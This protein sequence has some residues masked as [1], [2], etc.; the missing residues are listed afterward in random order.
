MAQG[1]PAPTSPQPDAVPPPPA[2]TEPALVPPPPAL[3][4]EP[5]TVAPAT[6]SPSTESP[7]QPM[8]PE[9]APALPLR[10]NVNPEAP[11]ES[12]PVPVKGKWNP[13]LYGFVEFD[14][15]HD[16]TQSFNDLAGNAPI[17]TGFQGSHPRTM[18]SVRNSRLGFK[19]SAPETSGIRATGVLEMDFLGNQPTDASENALFTNPTFR[20]RHFALKLENRYVDVLLGQYWQ[21]FGWQSFFHPNTVEI[22]GVP[23]QVYTR[24]PQARLSHKFDTD[25]VTVELAA[26]ASRPVERDSGVPDLTAGLRLSING[27]KGLHTSGAGATATAQDAM[28]IGVSAIGRHLSVPEFSASPSDTVSKNAGGISIDAM[29]PVIPRSLEHRGNA[30]TLTG[31]FVTG[32]GISDLYTGLTGG[33][34]YPS[35]P[36]PTNAAPAPTYTADL[37]K[38]IATFDSNGN[39]HTINWLSYMVGAQY[40]LPPSG[41]FW[42]AANFSHMNSSNLHDFVSATT[43]SKVFT[44]S[45]WFDGN[46]L[47][48]ALP[49]VRFGLEYAYFHQTYANDKDAHNQ[50][51][52]FSGFY[53]F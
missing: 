26:S 4:P 40:Y 10:T 12:G 39:L 45:Y 27:W 20:I 44:K 29:L 18:F 15:I 6:P 11:L 31:S 52:Q 37:D 13:V 28:S 5:A 51:W 48:D 46:L 38:G 49:S 33:I 32:T 36:N 22:Q 24:T 17:K 21:L 35:L 8:T 43:A 3:A 16:S 1:A 2:R 19:M 30:F 47:W 9:G 50:R 7:A 14:S 25:A 42:L 34:D 53:L 41:R 23:G